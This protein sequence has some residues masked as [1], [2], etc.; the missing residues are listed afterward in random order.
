MKKLIAALLL[1]GTSLVAFQAQA[2][3]SEPTEKPTASRKSSRKASGEDIAKMQRRMSMNPDEVKRDQ[4]MEILEARSGGLLTPASAV[5]RAR[6]GSTKKAVQ[7]SRYASSKTSAVRPSRSAARAAAHPASTPRASLCR[8][9][10]NTA[11]CSFRK[12]GLLA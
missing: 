10:R 11:S 3:S 2:Q 4:Q 5:L 7:V 1:A 12:L 8:T 6:L 9:K